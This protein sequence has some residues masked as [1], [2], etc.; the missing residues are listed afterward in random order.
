MKML[1]HCLLIA[2]V[3]G[4]FLLLPSTSRADIVGSTTIKCFQGNS[5]VSC[6]PPPPGFR[7]GDVVA[8]SKVE[9]S[10]I[11]AAVDAAQVLQRAYE[12]IRDIMASNPVAIYDAYKTYQE[13]IE[14]N[15]STS[16]K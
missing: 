16:D 14:L 9:A 5:Q 13:A 11:E 7:N 8:G 10:W 6:Q 15:Q 12:T 4:L 2:L 3:I 1:R